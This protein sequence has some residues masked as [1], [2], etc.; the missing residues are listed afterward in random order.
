MAKIL[1]RVDFKG[2]LEIPQRY[3]KL[4][5][6]DAEGNVLSVDPDDY[7][8]ET[9]KENIESGDFKIQLVETLVNGS[10]RDKEYEIDYKEDT[11][12]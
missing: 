3:L 10:I 9:L 7:S 11:G 6:T 2:S 8:P 1:F 4:T 5:R 12:F